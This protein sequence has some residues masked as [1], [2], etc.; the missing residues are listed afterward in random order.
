MRPP[1]T[2]DALHPADKA[3]D[4]TAAAS[5]WQRLP[6][7]G[8]FFVRFWG[9]VSLLALLAGIGLQELSSRHRTT[10]AVAG[11]NKP[12]AAPQVAQPQPA[13]E[14]A[15][16]PPTAV[17]ANIPPDPQKVDASSEVTPGVA[18]IPQ[19][20]PDLLEPVEGDPGHS[21]PKVGPHGE[22]SRNVYAAAIPSVP[23]G[24]AR[25]AI[26]LDGYGLSED[27]SLNAAR[28]L[29]AMVSF[30]VPA[31]AP[32]RQLLSETARLRGHETFL[33]LPMQPSTA[34]LDDEGPRALGYDHT[35]EADKE[36]LEWA[37]S[38][39]NGYVGVTNAF[40]GLD[41]D[42]YAQSPDFRMVSHILDSRGLLYLNATPGAPR[43][44]PVMGG[45][46]SLTM[47]TN[48]DAA[49]V[50]GQL[51]RLVAMAKSR[52]TATA[53]AGPMR[54]V[55]L[56]RLIE[57]THSLSNQG[58][59]LVPV[60]ALSRNAP[61]S[62]SVSDSRTLHVTVPAVASQPSPTPVVAPAKVGTASGK[63]SVTETPLASPASTPEQTASPPA[64]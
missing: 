15:P 40:S 8:R 19:P 17:A 54:P 62:P 16:K 61:L 60:S 11:Q 41:G 31:Y 47:D 38:R 5:L 3:L 37:L 52:G 50:D 30:A 43:S 22:M 48:T 59:T 39:F 36:N 23:A 51:A 42:A 27:M 63:R 20:M 18:P 56:Q 45:D 12:V 4:G 9:G 46:A 2:N 1:I 49:G 13:K 24:N 14:V 28:N 53:V 35:A 58:V 44:G 57:W 7:N 10:A 32:A 21:L 25:I 64:P 26:L 29:P 6:P 34:P 55:F 33:S